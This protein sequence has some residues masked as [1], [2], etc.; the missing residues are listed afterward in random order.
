L[1]Q[2]ASTAGNGSGLLQQ[3]VSS[4]VPQGIVHRRGERERS[5]NDGSRFHSEIFSLLL[6]PSAFGER[7]H[8][9][10]APTYAGI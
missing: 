4:Y 5:G 2:C 1:S 7:C 8:R 9:S 10:L 3:I 6:A